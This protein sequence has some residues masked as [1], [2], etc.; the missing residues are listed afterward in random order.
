MVKKRR[1]RRKRSTKVSKNVKRFVN[2]KLKKEVETKYNDYY[3]SGTF[4][5]NGSVYY[6]LTVIP[7]GTTDSNRI[8]DKI[9]LRGI[10]LRYH[11][12]CGDTY[13]IC[14]IVVFQYYGNNTLHAPAVNELFQSI[15]MGTVY[16][17]MSPFTFDYKNQFGI[18]YDK[19]HNLNLN[20]RQTVGVNKKIK[21]KYAKH[22]I[23]FTAATTAG[24]NQ[25][26][27]V[28][29][30][31]SGAATHPSIIFHSRLFYDDA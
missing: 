20:D 1:V 24:S 16:A 19:T 18:L 29:L 25:I 7:Q 15:Y 28:A 12:L 26:Y 23:T 30:S 5:W 17:P 10:R 31:D 27:I 13:N 9:S 6:N 22:G 3:N 2:K 4:D 14:R 11:L 21:I 8:G